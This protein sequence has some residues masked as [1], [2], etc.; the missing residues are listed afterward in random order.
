VINHTS[1]QHPW[2]QTARQAS[3]CPERDFYVWSDTDHK[4]KARIIFTDAELSNWTWDAVAEQYYWRP[5]FSH[6]PDLNYDS[7][8][9]MEEVLTR[10]WLNMGVAARVD[11]VPYLVEREG[12]NCENLSKI[13][14]IVTWHHIAFSGSNFKGGRNLW[15]LQWR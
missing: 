1:D 4:Y 6:Q 14:T 5:S 11:A 13:H 10:Y 12:T 3:D 7:P 2:F 9:V 15:K 8:K